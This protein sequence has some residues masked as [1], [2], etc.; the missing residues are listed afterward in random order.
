MYLT[1]IGSLSASKLACNHQN[2]WIFGET[3]PVTNIIHIKTT[4]RSNHT[5][6]NILKCNRK[7]FEIDAYSV[8]N[9]DVQMYMDLN[10][11]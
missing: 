8:T 10:H 1:T 3:F 2:T 11:A 6:Y 4:R 9:V 5:L 7:S